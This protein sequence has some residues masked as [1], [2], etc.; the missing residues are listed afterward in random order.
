[1]QIRPAFWGVLIVLIS[2]LVGF[3]FSGAIIYLRLLYFGSFLILLCFLWTYFSLR[4]VTVKRT[5]RFLRQSVGQVFEERFE[6][7]NDHFLLKLWIDIRDMSGLPGQKGSKVLTWVGPHQRR[8]YVAYTRLMYRGQF[9]LGPTIVSS[10]DPFGL[11]SYVR[12]FPGDRPLLV[13]PYMVD[14]KNIPTPPGVL[15]GGKALR[16]RTVD[17]TP[18]GA[19]V[20]EYAPGDSLNRIHWPTTARKDRLMVKEFDQDPQADIWILIDAQAKA[21]LVLP[22]ENGDASEENAERLWIWRHQYKFQLPNNTFDYVIS[23]AASIA[24]HYI[25]LGKAVGLAGAGQTFI[26]LSSERGERQLGKILEMLAFINA[27]GKLPLDGVVE[28]QAP[29]LARGSTVIM[30]T[31]SE[32]KTIEVAV[33]DLTHRDLEPVVILIDRVSFQGNGQ[34]QDLMLRLRGRGVPVILISKGANLKSAL[35]QGYS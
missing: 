2:G 34:P 3:A 19:G 8:S 24:N 21:Q 16:R 11:F 12:V 6:I 22:D 32:N 30:I 15:P 17:V 29:H 5:A 7:I 20:R 14:I 23:T 33:D 28:A 31:P 27:D 1:M 4:G 26:V 25:Q 18:Y 13:L 9:L 10:G 35:E